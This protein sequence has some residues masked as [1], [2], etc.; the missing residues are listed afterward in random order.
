LKFRG[1]N[2]VFI[3]MFCFQQYHLVSIPSLGFA[4]LN[5]HICLVCNIYLSFEYF[6]LKSMSF[7]F[8]L[9]PR[10]YLP[11]EFHSLECVKFP[12]EV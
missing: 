11:L 8:F 12:L 1:C 6:I 7:H 4:N 10:I 3:G 5:F 2:L 9:F